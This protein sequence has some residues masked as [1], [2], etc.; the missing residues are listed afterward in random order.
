MAERTVEDRLRQEYF[1]LLPEARRVLGELETKVRHCLLPLS[2]RLN[3]Y[4]RLVVT[5]RVKDCE[6]ALEALRRRQEGATFDPE[7]GESY[8]LTSLNDL[9]GV[10]V[11]AFPKG[12]LTEADATL[13][14]HT[15]FSSWSPDPV[16]SDAG[17]EPLALK[18]HG[19]CEG[20][21]KVR[22]ELQ[23]V[24]MLI[25][26]FWQI[27][28]SAIYKPSPE[29]KGVSESLEMRQRTSD[30]L[31][32]LQAF[33]E[34][35]ERLVQRD[36]LKKSRVLTSRASADVS[37]CLDAPSCGIRY[38][39]GALRNSSARRGRNWHAIRSSPSPRIL[40]PTIILSAP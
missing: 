29:L 4:E 14:R 17:E 38:F 2:N 24:P 5:S 31:R 12:R 15:L 27:E 25:G 7:R 18:Y 6:S 39:V 37:P 34:S 40:E 36:P 21:S 11:L 19:N 1:L 28:H 16:P 32:A 23:I 20:S 3:K 35:F 10:R 9:A 30:V 22:G 13:R 33:E 26:L 8:T